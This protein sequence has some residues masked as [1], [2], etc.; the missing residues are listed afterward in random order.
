MHFV[1]L[2]AWNDFLSINQWKLCLRHA[3]YLLALINILNCIIECVFDRKLHKVHNWHSLLKGIVNVWWTFSL[4]KQPGC[5]V[6]LN[7]A[8]THTH[9]HNRKRK[10][11]WWVH[12]I[13]AFV[14]F[15]PSWV[16]YRIFT[17]NNFM[18]IFFFIK[19]LDNIASFMIERRWENMQNSTMHIICFW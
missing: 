10:A 14:C 18:Y 13:C 17:W 1:W 6:C 16:W 4:L 3:S 2:R 15:H 8:H 5:L 11:F 9:C 7:N 12:H 19:Y